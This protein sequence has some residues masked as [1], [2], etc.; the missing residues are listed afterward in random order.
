MNSSVK[1]FAPRVS[2]LPLPGW[3]L[4]ALGPELE[5]LELLLLDPQ[6]A[7]PTASAT[8]SSATIVRYH[9]LLVITSLP[10]VV[11]YLRAPIPSLPRRAACRAAPAASPIAAAA[12]TR[13]R[14]GT[15]APR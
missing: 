12:R 9:V 1:F 11:M 13:R 4:G 10:V 8:A 14:R 2:D 6:A 3:P 15:R 7:R 5:L